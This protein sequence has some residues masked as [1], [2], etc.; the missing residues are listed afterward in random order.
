MG[1]FDQLVNLGSKAAK[2]I[3]ETNKEFDAKKR[4]YENYSDDRL[5][6]IVK[7][8]GFLASSHFEKTAA[9]SILIARGYSKEDIKNMA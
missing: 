1:F 5:I 8:T 3:A 9:Y 7:S 6:K 2:A 4:E